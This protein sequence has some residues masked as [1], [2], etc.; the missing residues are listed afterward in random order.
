MFPDIRIVLSSPPFHRLQ[1]VKQKQ[2]EATDRTAAS[3]LLLN[4]MLIT[5]S[6]NDLLD[7]AH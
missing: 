2:P 4:L 1:A 5:V 6:W 7:S 3:F